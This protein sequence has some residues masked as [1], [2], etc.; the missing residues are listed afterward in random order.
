MLRA[1]GF[2]PDRPVDFASV[3]VE[4]AE[5]VVAETMDFGIPVRTWLVEALDRDRSADSRDAENVRRVRAALLGHGYREAAHFNVT[6]FCDEVA[7]FGLRSKEH[8]CTTNLVF[9]RPDLVWDLAAVDAGDAP[10][11]DLERPLECCGCEDLARAI[12]A[13]ADER[14]R[15]DA[16]ARGAVAMEGSPVT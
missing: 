14:D 8:P 6:Q 16:A 10:A 13:R 1:A 3:D 4:G 7:G 11:P 9:E 2:G 5:H 12:A 15:R